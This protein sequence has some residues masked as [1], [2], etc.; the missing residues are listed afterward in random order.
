MSLIEAKTMKFEKHCRRCADLLGAPFPEVNRWIDELA[1][2]QGTGWEGVRFDPG[3]RR[4]RHHMVGIEQ[5][6]QL[7]GE[8]AAQAA[9]L[10]ILDDLYGPVPHSVHHEIPLDEA[11]YLRKGWH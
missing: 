10:H 8:R 7:W 6:K 4:Y 9:A 3:H 5:A 1:W 2:V 11:D